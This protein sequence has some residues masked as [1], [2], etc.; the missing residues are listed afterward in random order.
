MIRIFVV[1]DS[2]FIRKALARVLEGE[3]G[4]TLVGQAASGREALEKIPPADPDLVTL[5]I[6]MP[7][8]GGQDVL[9]ELLRW[10]PRLKVVMLSAHTSEGAEASIEALAAGAVD[11][12]DKASF[13]LMDLDTLRSEVI[14]KLRVWIPRTSGPTPR[15]GRVSS[16]GTRA[17]GLGAAARAE[18]CVI[19][20]STGGPIALQRILE[21]LPGSFPI[22]IVVVQHMPVGFTG[23]FAERLN[24][25]SQLAVSEAAEGDRLRPGRALVAPAGRHLRI[26]SGLAVTLADAPMDGR[27]VPSVDVTMTSA[28]AARPGKV[29]GI[30][31]TGMGQDG[32]EGMGAIRSGGGFT[33]G[34]S[35]ASCVVFGMSRA[36]EMQGAVDSMLAL[37]EI[38]EFLAG[39]AVPPYRRTAIP[40]YE[41]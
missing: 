34:E 36:A 4:L 1:D 7:G 15:L 24:R 12:I 3:P 2:P 25:I 26:T 40:P 5:D 29:L 20:A 38:V 37:D 10:K 35:Q 14:E 6:A 18:I 11:F 28:A 17:A 9:R 23:P 31:L 16:N 19:G 8:I 21:E 22:P 27:H 13:N 30:L 32:A 39:V 33:I 41:G